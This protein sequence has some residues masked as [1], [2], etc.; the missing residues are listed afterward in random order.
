M[1]GLIVL[2]T[3]SI[4]MSFSDWSGRYSLYILPI[5]YFFSGHGFIIYSPKLK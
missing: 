3:L 4:G 1:V 5:I 2:L